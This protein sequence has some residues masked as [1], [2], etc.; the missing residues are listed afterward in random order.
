MASSF[1]Y[2]NVLEPNSLEFVGYELRSFLN[3]AFVLIESA[4]AG[5][6]EKLLE[7]VQETLLVVARER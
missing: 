7:F 4:D 5:D 2:F 1:N 3:V 6:P